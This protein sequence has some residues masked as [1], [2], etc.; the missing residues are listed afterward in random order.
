M[1]LTT[2]GAQD[3]HTLDLFTAPG[4]GSDAY[5]PSC[6]TGSV[7]R[8]DKFYSLMRQFVLQGF[9]W[10]AA[11]AWAPAAV[12]AYCTMLESGPL[13]YVCTCL[14]GHPASV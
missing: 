1:G 13:A 4:H 12:E 3:A 9:E 10:M 2:T 6:G 8:L 5:A 7:F 11:R 14:P